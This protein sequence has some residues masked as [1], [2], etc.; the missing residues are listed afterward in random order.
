MAAVQKVLV[1][2]GGFSGMSAAIML[3]RGGVETDLVEISA[4]WRS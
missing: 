4:G 1:I 3:A 2:G